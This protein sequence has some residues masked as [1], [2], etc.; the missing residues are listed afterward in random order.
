[1]LNRKLLLFSTFVLFFSLVMSANAATTL[2]EIGRSPFHQPPL[3]TVDE[4]I[5]MVQN[6]KAEVEKGFA[7]SGRSDLFAP[8]M[9]QITT[10]P[11]NTVEF[12]KGSWFE[13]MFY[14]KKGKGTVRIVRDVTWG[15][16]KT[17]LG[18]MFYIDNDGTRYT[19]VVPLGCGNIALMGESAIPVVVQPP[20]P[21]LPP[22][23]QDP[24]CGM[25][26]SSVRAFCGEIITVD[27]S[28]SN[29]A[30]GDIAKM[31]IAF[32]DDRGQV[33][34][35]KVV[36]GN[37]LKADVQMPCGKNT[38][39]VMV[40]DDDGAEATSQ[41]CT[42]D[43][44]GMKRTRFL[45][46]LGYYRQFDPAHHV[47]GRVGLEYK[48]TEQF[49]VVGLI[50]AAPHVEGYD[51]ATAVLADLLAEYSF[52]RYFIDLGVGG[53]ITDGD[54]DIKAENSQLD[55]VAAFGAR[56]FGEPEAF[57]GS[58]F[59]EVRS[60]FDELDGIIDYGRFGIGL[61]FRF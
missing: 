5:D 41:Q 28:S 17:F 55:L 21:V 9:E 12:G 10:T 24:Q 32:V 43:V 38:L 52:S 60:A 30:D 44:E 50:G 47:F 3:K 14:K 6:K 46:D 42:V 36:D 18:F 29:D 56:V 13:W 35:E 26:V 49:G 39:K 7:I 1:M 54:D 45:A 23:N 61:R 27:A 53:W 57:N 31:T 51:G 16:D 58:L 48:F 34:S 33:V 4:L 15:N 25:T 22:P 11:I 40:T 8:F 20:P 19:F 2:M 59:F 37:V